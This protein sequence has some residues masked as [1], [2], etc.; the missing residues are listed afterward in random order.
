MKGRA[1]RQWRQTVYREHLFAVL[2]RTRWKNAGSHHVQC[3]ECGKEYRIESRV[4]RANHAAIHRCRD[5]TRESIRIGQTWQYE[6]AS[7][8]TRH[9]FVCD[10][11]D[12]DGKFAIRYFGR[13]WWTG[14]MD[15][16]IAMI[17]EAGEIR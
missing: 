16:F 17:H 10:G 9:V 3:L 12:H 14:N 11:P 6:T 5:K 15:K 7:G 1:R 8:H 13:C 4:R 2:D